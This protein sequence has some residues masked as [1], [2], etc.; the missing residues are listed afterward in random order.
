MGTISQIILLHLLY[1]T[2]QCLPRGHSS[3]A[4]GAEDG[5]AGVRHSPAAGQ[6]HEGQACHLQQRHGSG[7]SDGRGAQVEGLEARKVPQVGDGVVQQGAERQIQIG[8]G[9]RQAMEASASDSSEG[10]VERGQS[11]KVPKHLKPPVVEIQASAEAKRFEVFQV[12]QAHETIRTK[13]AEFSIKGLQALQIPQGTHASIGD[14]AAIRQ[15]E[16]GQ[17]LQALESCQAFVR[18]A[19]VGEVQGF[20]VHHPRQA[21]EEPLVC[22]SAAPGQAKLP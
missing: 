9:W 5:K 22:D 20:E 15:A 10:T 6:I 11:W 4:E 21:A 3:C 19:A 16:I 18:N 14:E 2:V 17:L 1:S 7:V 8:E 12:R 13:L